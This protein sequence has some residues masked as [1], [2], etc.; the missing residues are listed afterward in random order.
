MTLHFKI[1]IVC[2]CALAIFGLAGLYISGF[3]GA[4]PAWKFYLIEFLAVI[5]FGAIISDLFEVVE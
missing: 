3:A 5:G 1:F 4:M 2:L